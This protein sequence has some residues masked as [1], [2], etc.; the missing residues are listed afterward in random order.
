MPREAPTTEEPD[1]PTPPSPPTPTD[2]DLVAEEIVERDHP[3]V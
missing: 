3:L 2:E 1:D